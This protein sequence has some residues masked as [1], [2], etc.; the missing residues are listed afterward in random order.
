MSR[1]R[2]ELLKRAR[3]KLAALKRR[4]EGDAAR[5]PFA[6]KIGELRRRRAQGK[7]VYTPEILAEAMKV[8]DDLE[9]ARRAANRAVLKGG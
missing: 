8:H 6:A 4:C 2:E 9:P 7:P 5:D 1:N 3:E